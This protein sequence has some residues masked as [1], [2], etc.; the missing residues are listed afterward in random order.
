VYDKDENGIFR[1]KHVTLFGCQVGET[2]GTFSLL[3][4]LQ[5]CRRGQATRLTAVG[6]I[7]DE[8]GKERDDKR[9]GERD[10]LTAGR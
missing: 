3:R 4:L 2:R 1:T 5:F 6:V 7:D 9:G 10:E 8:R